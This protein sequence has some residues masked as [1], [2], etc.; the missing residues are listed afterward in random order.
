[1]INRTIASFHWMKSQ[2]AYSRGDNRS[3][4]HHYAN[5]LKRREA[6]SV[7]KCFYGTLLILENQSDI[8]QKVFSELV[9]VLDSKKKDQNMMYVY[10]Y[11]KMYLSL[12]RKT[13]DEQKYRDL[14]DSARC[15]P[16]IKKW[17]P[18]PDVSQLSYK[19]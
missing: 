6:T 12:I 14:A 15:R 7:H 16:I 5:M 3:A 19:L 8:A 2:S 18:L 1:M 10:N 11:S 9:S 13:G 17:L 4:L